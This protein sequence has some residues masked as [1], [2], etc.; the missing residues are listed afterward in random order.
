MIRDIR[1]DEIHLIQDDPVRP[2]IGA[3]W[4]IRSGKRVL[5][6]EEDDQIKA[7]VC[8]RFMDEVPASE[9]DMK[10]QGINIAVFYT[11]WSYSPGSGRKII[12]EALKLLKSCYPYTT[13]AVTLSPPTDMARRFHLRNGA[14]ELRVNQ[15]SV[16]YEYDLSKQDT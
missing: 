14:S 7:V 9:S 16:N 15:N 13:R 5:V 11:V 2:H 12:Q 10:W 6:L 8:V 3:D 1:P 4:R